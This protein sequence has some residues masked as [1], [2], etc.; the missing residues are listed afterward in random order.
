MKDQTINKVLNQV[1][2][3]L[4]NNH[5]VKIKTSSKYIK[6]K[7]GTATTEVLQVKTGIAKTQTWR[8]VEPQ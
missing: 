7:I 6:M 4:N 2:K 1:Q 3:K 5:T 8:L